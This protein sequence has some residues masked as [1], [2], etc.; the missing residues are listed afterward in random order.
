MLLEPI[1]IAM[2]ASLYMVIVICMNYHISIDRSF[3]LFKSVVIWR[4]LWTWAGY[5]CHCIMVYKENLP[6]ARRIRGKSSGPFP[7]AR[8]VKSKRSGA[9][10]LAALP[11]AKRRSGRYKKQSDGGPVRASGRRKP[12]G[13]R[14]PVAACSG[15]V[16]PA[17]A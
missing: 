1:S 4:F 9:S 13:F 2:S 15:D 11:M 10:N 7:A 8:R 16:N 14:R 3:C 12:K 6:V 17:A 5:Q